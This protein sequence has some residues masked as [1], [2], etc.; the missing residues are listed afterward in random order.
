MKVNAV[1]RFHHTA[2]SRDISLRA[3]LII[4]P[5]LDEL[6]STPTPTYDSTASYST[7]AE[8]SS[9]ATISTRCITLG[10]MCR[11]MMRQW[12]T[13]NACAACTYSSSPTFSVSARSSRHS[14]DQPVMPRI[15]HSRNRRSSARSTPVAKFSAL[16]S[17]YTLIS[18]TKAAT[19]RIGGIAES[20]VYAYWMM[21]ST[22]PLK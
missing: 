5:K 8:K 12:L 14:V 10:R 3:R 18:S 1:A 15:T 6:G 2:G 17:M 11:R 22:Q 20:T 19:S 13:P 21:S 16:R 4:E 9:T 7:S